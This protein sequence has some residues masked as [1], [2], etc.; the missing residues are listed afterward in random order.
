ME[1]TTLS[2]EKERLIYQFVKRTFN[3]KSIESLTDLINKSEVKFNDWVCVQPK[4]RHFKRNPL[5]YLGRIVQIRCKS[6]LFIIRALDHHLYSWENRSF[7]VVNDS[8]ETLLDIGFPKL[9]TLDNE[10]NEYKIEGQGMKGFY[11]ETRYK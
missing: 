11:C 6:G 8:I 7:K 4:S 2:N 10:A 3:N 5:G 1:I 9:Y